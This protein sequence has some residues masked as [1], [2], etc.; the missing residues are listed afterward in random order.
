MNEPWTKMNLGILSIDDQE[1]LSNSRVL[2]VGC[3]GIGGHLANH[4]V[5]LGLGH[6]TLVDFD[7]FDA[8][9]L[10]RQLFSSTMTIEK[11]KANILQEELLKINPLAEINIIID[12]IENIPETNFSQIDYVLDALDSGPSKIALSHLAQRLGV[13]LLHG[14]CGGWYGQFGWIYPNSSVL[15]EIYET[16]QPGLEQTLKNPSFTPASVAAF[17]ASEFVK[18]IQHD[19]SV[20][21]TKVTLIDLKTNAILSIERRD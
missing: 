21:T 9:N 16:K 11:Y 3:G 8:T 15:E 17:M 10:N 6:L 14:S 1:H 12:R 13:P 4:L 2:L 18:M 5:R 20:S 19:E 7:R